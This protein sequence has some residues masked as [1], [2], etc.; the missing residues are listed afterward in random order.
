MNREITLAQAFSDCA[1][2][3][4]GSALSECSIKK[5]EEETALIGKLL[6]LTTIQGCLLSIIMSDEYF[7]TTISHLAEYLGMNVIDVVGLHREF[8]D[9]ADKGLITIEGRIPQGDWNE[10]YH[11]T[12]KM[13]TAVKRNSGIE[14]VDYSSY[15][16]NM[17]WTE[18][19]SVWS[20]RKENIILY[21][22][23][24]RCLAEM[25]NGCINVE[26]CGKIAR[27]RLGNDEMALLVV[28]VLYTQKDI[29]TIEDSVLND[30]F[31]NKVLENLLLEIHHGRGNLVEQNLLECEHLEC[32]YCLSL[33]RFAKRMLMGI[34]IPRVVELDSPEEKEEKCKEKDVTIKKKEMF[35]NASEEKEIERLKMMLG[36]DNYREI[37]RRMEDEGMNTGLT[38]LL[39]GAP[40]TGKTE[41]VKQIARETG[42]RIIQVDMSSLKSKWNGETEKNVNQVFVDYKDAL[43]CDEV[44]PILLFN[45]ADAI[46]SKRIKNV[47]SNNEQ[48]GNSVQNIL[49]E[50]MD[51]F[52]GIM[53]ATTNMTENFD[54]AFERRFLY[55]VCFSKPNADVRTKIW[56][57]RM[58]KLTDEEVTKLGGFY[59]LSGAQIDNVV[60]KVIVE[61]ILFGEQIDLDKIINLCKQEKM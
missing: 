47:Q 42:R 14:E 32:G 23:F 54:K 53:I 22:E 43:E 4:K 52:N 7:S 20:A 29:S 6:D 30:T 50:N 40:G 59:E 49:L 26:V 11:P 3:L 10:S 8:Q 2:L 45:E 28:A 19:K 21:E 44:E 39:F 37:V 16:E 58:P 17:F 34:I 12:M 41:T 57:S 1:K 31:P 55:K 60:R 48:H 56:K 5:A 35:Y 61:K 46:F 15:N 27:M 38:C 18:V 51:T 24:K 36:I 13:F 33:T 25:I 9:M